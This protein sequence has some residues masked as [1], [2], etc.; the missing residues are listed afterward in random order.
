MIELI[1]YNTKEKTSPGMENY[2]KMNIEICREKGRMNSPRHT[3][4]SLEIK[5]LQHHLL[6]PKK[7]GSIN[8]P[9]CP[10]TQRNDKGRSFNPNHKAPTHPTTNSPRIFSPSQ[11][12]SRK[13]HGESDQ[14]I[15][16]KLVENYARNP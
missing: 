3:A 14:V 13:I 7:K 16:I 5:I 6:K 2:T 12:T 4:Q 1:I 11:Q 15:N 8:N 10:T 9:W